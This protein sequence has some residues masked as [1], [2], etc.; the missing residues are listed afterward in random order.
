MESTLQDTH[1]VPET[2]R[3]NGLGPS[4]TS[5]SGS[6]LAGLPPDPAGTDA[7]HTGERASV[8]PDD[9]TRTG[10]DVLPDEVVDEESAVRSHP[11]DDEDD[12]TRPR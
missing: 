10:S 8:D 1:P 2:P 11:G 12:A 4:D 7:S 3:D 9:E 6:D 5:D